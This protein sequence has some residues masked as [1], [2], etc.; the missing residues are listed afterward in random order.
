MAFLV[1]GHPIAHQLAGPSVPPLPH[2]QPKLL[3]QIREC[4]VN[5]LTAGQLGKEEKVRLI[6]KYVTSLKS[7]Q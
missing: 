6:E 4:L 3:P 5:K 7:K 1:D 2:Q